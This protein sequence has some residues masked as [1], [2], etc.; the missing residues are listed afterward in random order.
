MKKAIL[1]LLLLFFF[2]EVQSA[3][4]FNPKYL[5]EAYVEIEKSG[6]IYIDGEINSISLYL[7][8]PQENLKKIEVYPNDWNLIEDKFGNLMI[9]INFKEIKPVLNY[10]VKFFIKSYWKNWE[11]FDSNEWFL[12][13]S[14]KETS[15]TKVNNEM[16]KLAYGKEDILEKVARLSIWINRNI[17]YEASNSKTKI[18]SSLDVWKIRKGACGE[19]SNLL[20]ALL[21]SQEIPCRYIVGYAIAENSSEFSHAWMEVYYNGKWVPFDP[22]WLEGNYLDAAHI[23]IANLLDSNFT[24]KIEYS[25]NGYV[26]WVPNEDK[27]KLLKYKEGNPFNFSIK[28][29]KNVFGYSA[30]LLNLSFNG[31]GLYKF[32]LVSCIDKNFNPLFEIEDSK[33]VYWICGK[34]S[35]YWVLV[36]KIVKPGYILYCPISLFINDKEVWNDS[37]KI[38]GMK[39][40]SEVKLNYP[41]LA[42]AG[43]KIKILSNKKG[44]FFSPN[45]TYSKEGSEW[46]LI[47]KKPGNYL[48]YFY[49][50]NSF[51]KA[52]IEVVDK[53]N[54][55]IKSLE[56][57]ERVYKGYPFLLNFTVKN[58]ENKE[59][60]GKAKIKIGNIL[61]SLNLTF[62]PK[63]IKKLIFNISLN[64]TG[65]LDGIISIEDDIP[66]YSSFSVFVEEKQKNLLIKIIQSIISFLLSL[67]R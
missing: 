51:G 61:Y 6:K 28:F 4:A 58:L 25:G 43:E 65:K 21:R 49:S 52:E 23:K 26:N 7:Y 8:V 67:F 53:L 63:E 38:S 64:Q 34:N 60:K 62:K 14:K 1:I 13:E 66:S 31:C 40:F 45:F 50:D 10:S 30:N 57:P 20:I 42:K 47:F 19:Y 41:S 17:K 36:S 2:F 5:K 9:K 59:T 48:I 55:L 46:D 12:E 44:I 3:F 56:I 22:T 29:S 37:T 54:F 11:N 35:I 32:E 18:Y 39:K 16:R 27:V 33:R 15:L 24:E